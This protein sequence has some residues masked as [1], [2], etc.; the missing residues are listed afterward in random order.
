MTAGDA[1]GRRTRGCRVRSELE[2]ISGH[3]S[4]VSTTDGEG[5]RMETLKR[6][7]LAGERAH[8]QLK[9]VFNERVR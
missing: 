6:L 1:G 3:G 9:L 7:P 8:T 2:R 4:G 5:G